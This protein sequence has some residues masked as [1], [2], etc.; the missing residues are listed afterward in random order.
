MKKIFFKLLICVLPVRAYS[1]QTQE[2]PP[3]VT[4]EIPKHDT[5]IY[6]NDSI[7]L[8]EVSY[9]GAGSR[10]IKSFYNSGK[11]YELRYERRREKVTFVYDP[12]GTLIEANLIKGR[13]KSKVYNGEGYVVYETNNTVV[14]VDTK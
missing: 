6:G 2:T 3:S 14:R 13:E 1:Q 5:I 12:A 9:M 10:I 8:L 11:L 7:P 4:F